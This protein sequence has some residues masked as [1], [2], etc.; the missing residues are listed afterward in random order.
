MHYDIIGDLHGHADAL[1]SLLRKMDYVH[2][3]GAWR[4]SERTAVFVG[5]FIDRGPQQQRT[6]ERVRA[7]VETG[8]ALAVMGNHELNA[9]AWHTPH[10]DRPGEFLRSHDHPV[11][12]AKN[13]RQHARFLMEVAHDADR[14]RDI[15]DW[16][17]TLP[18]WLELPGIRVVHA[19][20]H[21][22][23]MDWLAPHLT[24]DRQLTTDLLA[25]A[26]Q[27]PAHRAENGRATP[28]VF[29][30]VE[31]LLKGLDVPLPSP[32]HFLDKDG[33]ERTDVRVRWWDPNARTYRDT[34]LL[35]DEQR[36]Q[37]P[38]LAIPR[39][40]QVPLPQG[41]PLFFGH[42]WMRGAP[43]VLAPQV[44]CVD[45]SVALQGGTLAAYRWSGES[46]LD[47]RHFVTSA[48]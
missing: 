24:A 35:A 47:P 41:K 10:P 15:I 9:I 27:E 11:W 8:A 17:M 42:Y 48:P 1:E 16:F 33:I 14:H 40:A 38:D 46:V 5:D 31:A 3:N 28:S 19:C 22:P 13:F 2:S 25:P 6:V 32:H 29:K 23:L 7:M 4:H 34:A 20:W 39:H 21:Q 45:Y 12:G 18:L 26:T 37:L 43:A 44:A 36:R 30:A